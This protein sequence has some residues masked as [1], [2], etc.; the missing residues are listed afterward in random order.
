M[1]PHPFPRFHPLPSLIWQ[2][3][4]GALKLERRREERKASS[5]SVAAS[6]TDGAAR[7]GITTVEIVDRSAQGMGVLS[8]TEIAPGMRVQVRPDGART[9]WISGIAVR[10]EPERGMFR[11]GLRLS[12]AP[13]A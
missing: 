10:S 4:H 3:P 5:G 6:Y 7:F 12:H 1:K 9:A 13:A 8:P 11:I 2:D